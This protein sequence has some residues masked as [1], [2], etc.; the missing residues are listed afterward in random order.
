MVRARRALIV[1]TLVCASVAAQKPTPASPSYSRIIEMY[2]TGHENDALDA[3]SLMLRSEQDAAQD[4]RLK[5]FAL[6]GGADARRMAAE[7]R[8]AAMLHTERAFIELAVHNAA[9]FRYQFSLAQAYSQKLASYDRASP[10]AERWLLY[11]ISKLH[12]RWEVVAARGVCKLAHSTISDTAELLLACGA[13]EEMGWALEH[14]SDGASRVKGDLKEAERHFRNALAMNSSLVE[15]RLRLGRVLTLRNDPEGMT[16]L[17]AIVPGKDDG[18]SYLAR[19]F[20]GDAL[21][22]SGDSAGAERRYMTA[23]ALLPTGQSAYIALAH[24]RH[25][26]GARSEAAADV[27]ALAR[28]RTLPDTSEPWFWYAR[29]LAWRAGGYSDELRAIVRQ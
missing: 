24:L 2:R 29:G 11:T 19:L 8:V 26:R 20:E 18:F 5:A 16:T 22:R 12:I 3:L 25:A 7:L 9:E 1:V 28:D 15:A 21:E 17:E 27:T 6:S 4:S 10:F 23:I 13:T 14:N